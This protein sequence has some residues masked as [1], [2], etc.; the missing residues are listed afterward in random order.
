MSTYSIT[1]D[2]STAQSQALLAYLDTLPVQLTKISAVRKRKNGLGQSEGDICKRRV[3][4][5]ANADEMCKVLCVEQHATN[6]ITPELQARLDAA[7]KD[8]KEGRGTVCRTQE[9]LHAFLSA[10]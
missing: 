10:L 3:Q 8:I 9:E 2:E 7:R 4:R 5:F 1:L 6:S